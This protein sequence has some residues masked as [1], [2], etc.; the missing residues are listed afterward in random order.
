MATWHQN[1]ART[2]LWHDTQWTVVSDPPN[3][4]RTI[5]RCDTQAQA[6]EYLARIKPREPHSYII[7]PAK[8]S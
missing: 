5:T 2:P 4:L 6:E 7:R 3:D 1:R 8:K